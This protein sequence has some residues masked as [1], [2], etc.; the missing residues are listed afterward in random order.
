MKIKENLVQRQLA[1]QHHP[2]CVERFCLFHLA[3]PIHDKLKHV[4][5][6]FVVAD[7][8]GHD[9][10]LVDVIDFRRVRKVNRIID[11]HLFAR[12]QKYLIDHA[13]IGADDVEIVFAAEPFLD[14]FHVKQA[15]KSA[16]ISET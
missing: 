16:A 3:P 4:S 1:G 10:R 7:H 9:H 13:G 5:D 8:I 12:F 14:D 11:F 2:A 6:V 15:E